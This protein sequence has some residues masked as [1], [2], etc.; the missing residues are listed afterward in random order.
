MLRWWQLLI[1]KCLWWWQSDI[2]STE[3]T[4]LNQH[5]QDVIRVSLSPWWAYTETQEGHPT[6]TAMCHG[7]PSAIF[8]ISSWGKF[9]LS[10][11][12][13]SDKNE[14]SY[15]PCEYY[16]SKNL[17]LQYHNYN[18]SPPQEDK[19]TSFLSKNNCHCLY[20]CVGCVHVEFRGQLA[21]RSQGP[22]AARVCLPIWGK[23]LLLLFL[24]YNTVF[25]LQCVPC[26]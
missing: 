3:Q 9:I 16:S 11:K 7:C 19:D 22:L 10:S 15:W 2:H 12:P 6:A 1:L 23:S 24:A 18:F 25:A 20:L 21:C 26:L 17:N 8:C 4:T 13:P 14:C 5:T